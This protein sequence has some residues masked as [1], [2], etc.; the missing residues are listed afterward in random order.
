MGRI[1]G[2]EKLEEFDELAA[3]MAILSFTLGPTNSIEPPENDS[4]FGNDDLVARFTQSE[5]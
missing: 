5:G 2:I 1:G 3:A 4:K